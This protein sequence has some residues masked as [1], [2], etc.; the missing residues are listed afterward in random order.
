[1]TYGRKS[2]RNHLLLMVNLVINGESKKKG[3]VEMEKGISSSATKEK[4]NNS[5][6]KGAEMHLFTFMSNANS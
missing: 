3:K 5:S 2:L 1:M 6:T 4:D